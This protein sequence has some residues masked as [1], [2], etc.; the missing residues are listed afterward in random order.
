[1]GTPGGVTLRALRESRRRSQLWVE[2]EAELGT[3]YLQRL[4]SGRVVQPGSATLERILVAL[5]ARYDE[6]REILARFGYAA[7]TP[8]PT[9]DDLAQARA[10]CQHELDAVAFPAYVLDCAHRLVA[11]NRSFPRLLGVGPGDPLLGR[12]AGRSLLAPWF[13]PASPLA[14]LVAEPDRLLPALIRAC[15]FEGRR[16]GG[17]PW[18]APMV[19][20]P[21]LALPRFRHHWELVAREPE[22]AGAGRALVPL[23]LDLPRVGRLQFRLAA[24]PFGRDARF[25]TI[26]YFPA[27]PPS[28]RRCA[29]WAE[30]SVVGSP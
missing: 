23:L 19:L 7:T 8:L 2:A 28:M 22:A 24:E 29:D 6:R 15:R 25:R 3:G 9:A 20:D 16:F 1:M 18:Y 26:Y 17:E 14:P 10:E 27:D 11:W 5:G 4:E 21:L 30:Q 13:D 12:L